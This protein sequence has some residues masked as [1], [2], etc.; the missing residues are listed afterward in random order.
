MRLKRY[1]FLFISIFLLFNG[2]VFSQAYNRPESAAYDAINNLY[3]ISNTGTPTVANE[4][5]LNAVKPDDTDNIVDTISGIANSIRGIAINNT[6]MIAASTALGSTDQVLLFIDLTNG[7]VYNEITITEGNFIN[8]VAIN[9]DGTKAYLSDNNNIYEIDVNTNSYNVILKDAG[10]NGLLFEGQ[11]NR[12]LFTDDTFPGGAS[13]VSSI[14]LTNYNV[15]R[16]LWYINTDNI[17]DGLT[18][19]HMGNYYISCWSDPNRIYRLEPGSQTRT[20]AYNAVNAQDGM[21]AAD[22]FYDLQKNLMI[23][24]LM[25][26]NDVEFIPFSQLSTE[27][28]GAIPQKISLRQNFP[29]PFNP[30]TSISYDINKES[31]VKLTVYDLLGS[32][33]IQLVNQTE[34]PGIKVVQWDGRNNKG[35]L[36]NGGV[37]LYKLEIGDY[38]ETKKMVLLK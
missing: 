31:S 37:Y 25:N 34:Q 1:S 22:I 23:V 21:G 5:N 18:I 17:L 26:I 35:E 15:S 8:D 11:N 16:M 12:L 10:A 4:G 32:E 6:T 14:D 27:N 3:W 9:N 19:D 38:I 13:A 7:T 30:S 33:I 20:V 29:N 2:F 36:V 24:P 28:E